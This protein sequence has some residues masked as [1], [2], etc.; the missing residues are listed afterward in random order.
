[1]LNEF[2]AA[3]QHLDEKYEWLGSPQAYISLKHEGDKV[4]VFERAGLLFVFNF[5]ATVSSPSSVEKSVRMS[6]LIGITK[7]RTALPTTEWA[8]I[9][10]ASTRLS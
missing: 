10:R 6:C 7:F 5:H 9:A 3:M 1:M 4:I 2:D 8:L